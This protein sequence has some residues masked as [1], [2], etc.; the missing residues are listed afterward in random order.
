MQLIDTAANN[1]T[2]PPPT[3]QSADDDG[4]RFIASRYPNGLLT[5]CAEGLDDEDANG[6]PLLSFHPYTGVEFGPSTVFA[7]IGDVHMTLFAGTLKSIASAFD[8]GSDWRRR[9]RDPARSSGMVWRLSQRLAR[10]RC[11][12]SRLSTRQPRHKPTR[13]CAR[14]GSVLRKRSWPAGS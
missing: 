10:F 13:C 2:P 11:R 6:W 3:H 1:T 4:P 8:S 9:T 7:S 12:R 5:V 14:L